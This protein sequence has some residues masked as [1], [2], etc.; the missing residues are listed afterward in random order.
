MQ[1]ITNLNYCG[2][3][4][5]PDVLLSN[6]F[7]F[8]SVKALIQISRVNKQ[9]EK[10]SKGDDLR[11]KSCIQEFAIGSR[12]WMSFSNKGF[13]EEEL[14]LLPQDI[15][16]ILLGPSFVFP[17]K[18]VM[19][20]ERL[21]FIPEGI[22]F[23]MIHHNF[24]EIVK[25][26]RVDFSKTQTP[27]IVICKNT[28]KVYGNTSPKESTWMLITKE[29]IPGSVKNNYEKQIQLVSLLATQS[30]EAYEVPSPLEILAGMLGEFS[31][32]GRWLF[33]THSTRSNLNIN[34]K[35]IYGGSDKDFGAIFNPNFTHAS[36]D[37]GIAAVRKLKK[38]LS[39]NL[40]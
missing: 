19:E 4:K 10:V 30:N 7:S 5:F 23:N 28:F 27:D 18:T 14:E 26:K 11:R 24:L 15:H 8:L 33:R 38:P 13:T 34:N 6:T 32:T 36:K 9:W 35:P 20:V 16:K 40:V 3:N 2:F 37:M 1:T 17:G 21:V 12:K 31:K 39:K 25:D 22:H 29:V